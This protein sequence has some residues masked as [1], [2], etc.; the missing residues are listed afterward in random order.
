M[1]TFD[2]RE[3]VFEKKFAL[4]EERLFKAQARRN[5]MLGLWAAEALG[6]TGA[7]A[8]AY[9]LEIVAANVAATDDGEL[10]D[11]ITRDLSV[12]GVGAAE[13]GQKMDEFQMLADNPVKA[14]P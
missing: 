6:K 2:H 8:E 7:D 10:L 3:E 9:A 13:V 5:K 11:K 12:K 1:T 14:A 4:E